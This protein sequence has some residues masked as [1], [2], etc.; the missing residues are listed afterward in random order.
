[1][2]WLPAGPHPRSAA[3]WVPSSSM[4]MTWTSASRCFPVAKARLALAKMLVAPDPLL[5]LDEPTNHLDIDSVDVLEQALVRF[6]G[7]IVLISHDP[8]TSYAPW[9]SRWSTCATTR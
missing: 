9:L 7:T 4:A 3:S 2:P 8:S 1:M 6:P 5:C